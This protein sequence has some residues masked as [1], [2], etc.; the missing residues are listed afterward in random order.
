[1]A[2]E[3]KVALTL[4]TKNFNKKMKGAK[5][6]MSG[7]S[8]QGKVAQGSVIGLAAR[9]APLA[10][11]VVAVTAG[12]KGLSAS[13]GIASKFEDV[14]ITL[15]NIIGSA[16]G[17]AAALEVIKQAAEKLPFAFEDLAAAAPALSTVSGTIGELEENMMLAA[18]IA[19]TF[20]IPFEDAASQLQ[21]SFSAGAGA[22]D[23]FRE[24]GVLAAAGFEAGVKVSIDETIAKF[25]E[26][27]VEVEGAALTL[28]QTFSGAT[29]QAGDA[30]TLFGAS[31]GDAMMPEI[32]AFLNELTKIFRENKEEILAF[33]TAIGTTVVNSLIAFAQGVAI[34]IDIVLSLGQFASRIAQGIRQNFGEQIK[35]VANVVVKSF[36]AITEGIATVGIG[37]GK[38]IS[39]T[40]G[41]E[42]VENYFKAVEDAAEN[43]R[44]NGLDAIADTRVALGDMIPVTTARDAVNEFVADFTTGADEIRQSSSGLVDN[45]E[46]DM[47]DI[48]IALSG[49]GGAISAEEALKKIRGEMS[50]VASTINKLFNGPAMDFQKMFENGVFGKA[51]LSE[52]D[53]EKLLAMTKMELALVALGAQF[54]N[55]VVKVSEYNAAIAFLTDKFP[56]LGLSIEEAAELVAFL[57]EQF[58]DQEGMRNFLATLGQAQKALSTDLAT[59]LLEGKDAMESFKS[60]FK[61]MI[62]QIIADTLRLMIIQP[63]LGSLFGVQFGSGGNVTGMDFGGSFFGGLFGG[64][65]AAGGPVM[66]GKTYLVGE[67]GPELLSMGS[68]SGSITPNNMLGGGRTNVTYNINAVDAPSFQALVASDPEFMFSVTEA[69]R[70]RIPGVRVR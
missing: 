43:L 45:I 20:G 23:I 18:D 15:Q 30:L 66:A 50:K 13:L 64:G 55:N 65:K 17:G 41:D 58:E 59:A 24:K 35:A 4:D 39:L 69:G 11:G 28:N 9:F 54:E 53:T 63:I 14:R 46:G 70:R 44:T 33:G 61:T 7:F 49:G 40:T 16:E 12:F 62:T 27:G 67:K 21:R 57:N 19:A 47:R 8:S 3:I 5:S 37:L 32:T 60:F 56:E 2:K 38:L 26:F 34:A 42:T 6:S 25:R 29:S 10:A 22:A 36:A 51:G 52:G 1:M 68:N 48:G 31:I